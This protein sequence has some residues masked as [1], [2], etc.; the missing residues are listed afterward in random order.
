MFGSSRGPLH[1]EPAIWLGSVHAHS[2]DELAVEA[3]KEE[4]EE[5]KEELHLAGGRYY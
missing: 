3:K 2:H 5:E 4:D 1:P